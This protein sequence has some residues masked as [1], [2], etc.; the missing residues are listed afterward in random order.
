[1]YQTQI[2][3]G[4]VV[5]RLRACKHIKSTHSQAQ[6]SLNWRVVHPGVFHP[7]GDRPNDPL[8][9]AQ[10]ILRCLKSHSSNFQHGSSSFGASSDRLCAHFE[11]KTPACARFFVHLL[12]KPAKIVAIICPSTLVS[13]IAYLNRLIAM[14]L[15]F[16]RLGGG[17][18]ILVRDSWAKA[19]IQHDRASSV[20]GV[21]PR[22]DDKLDLY[23]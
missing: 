11:P 18:Y 5:S 2:Q 10:T 8:L 9:S 12:T 15:K 6:N 17:G 1:M 4:P 14:W 20:V 16:G 19:C 22:S 23:T 21:S 3:F 13:S 7:R